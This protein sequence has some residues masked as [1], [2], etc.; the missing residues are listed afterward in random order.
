MTEVFCPNK[1]A[2]VYAKLG[3]LLFRPTWPPYNCFGYA[4]EMLHFLLISAYCVQ[5]NAENSKLYG[6][7]Y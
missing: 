7:L 3:M 2:F 1:V 5:C 4:T 6:I